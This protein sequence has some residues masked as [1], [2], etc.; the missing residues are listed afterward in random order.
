MNSIRR[1]RLADALIEEIRRRILNGE[2]KKGDKLPNQSEFAAQLGVSRPSLREALNTLSL[3]GAIEQRPG[4]GTV[5]KAES[6]LLFTDHLAAP[7][8]SDA[9]AT[10]ELIESRRYI[11][12]DVVEMAA[13]SATQDEIRELGEIVD[14]M[15][16]ALK[17]GRIGGYTD[18]DLAFHYKIAEAAHNRF[19]LHMFVTLRGLMEQ[20][21]RE[22]FNVLPGLFE[23]S[24]KFHINICQAIGNRDVKKASRNMNRHIEDIQRA[25][26]HYYQV[27]LGDGLTTK[28]R[29]GP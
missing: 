3:I 29:K 12:A 26:A 15:P 7:M 14:Q 4:Y 23:R 2:L 6:P 13:K 11:E 24:L 22:T 28:A 20:F 25:L 1:V 19:M 27:T 18:L 10:L 5:I 9:Q 21:M 8:V 17:E 16:K